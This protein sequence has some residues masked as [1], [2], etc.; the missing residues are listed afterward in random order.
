MMSTGVQHGPGI[1]RSLF[2]HLPDGTPVE[3]F[4]LRTA[5]GMEMEVSAYGGAILCLRAPDRDG[6]PGDV[7]LGF[8]RLED[9]VADRAYF[10][11]LIGRYANR[12]RNGRFR[13]DGREHVLPVNDGANHLHGGPGGFHKVLWRVEPLREDGTVGVRLDYRSPDGEQGYPGNLDVTVTY[14]L[15]LEGALVI[16]YAAET[17]QATPVSL[18]QHTYFN[19][20]GDPARDVLDHEL[21]LRADR[22]TPVDAGLIPTGEMASVAGTPFDFRHPTT[23]GARIEDGDARLAR[24]GGYDHNFVVADGDAPLAY[25]ARVH[26]PLSGRVLELFTTEP[27][28]QFY[29][30]NYLDGGATGKDRQPYGYRCGFCLEPQKFPDSPNHPEFPTCILR[31]GERYA[32]RTVYRFTAE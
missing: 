10:G 17:D 6:R 13:L 21:E 26:E 27:G 20:S 28:L 4:A 31:P 11:A 8:D 24:V 19:L 14:R 3:R 18:T 12:I 23:I 30:G 1:E 29:S 5:S 9:Y 16:D 15:T 25:A 2:G 7:V 22:F 32:S